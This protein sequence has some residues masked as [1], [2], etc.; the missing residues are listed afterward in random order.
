M[1]VLVT[2]AGGFLGARV[3]AQLLDRG[4]A[5]RALL[6]PASGSAPGDWRDRAEI[7]RADLRNAPA[8]ESLF[9]GI[10]VLVHLAATVRGTPEA[11]F[12]GAVVCTEKLLEA[13]RRAGATQRV[14]LASSFSVYD[15]NAGAKCITEDSALES[16][17]YERDGYTVAKTWQERL[18]RR[19]AEESSWTVAVLR[20][21]LIYGPG[22]VPAAG[23]GIRL[24]RVFLAIAPQA[25]LRLTHVENCAAAF[26]N[27]VEKGAAGTFNIVDDEH[28]SAWR[29][30]GRLLEKSGRS[31][32]LTIPYSF[33]LAV[34]YAAKITSRVLFPPNGGKLPGI[35]IPLLYR[36]RFKPMQ[37]DNSRA[38]EVLDWKCKPL[39]EAGS[40]V[41]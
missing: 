8:L 27:A 12:I 29:Y 2:G 40:D 35:L 41:I 10:D 33:G 22:A 37:Y 7:V 1:K 24:G 31:F 39:F 16:R 21:G 34:A 11:Q 20:P 26:V 36:V 4:H 17:L 18:V 19:M 15:W 5:V 13:M 6:R 32:R 28:I 30:A 25:R 14:V 9:D 3:V 38:K 23:A